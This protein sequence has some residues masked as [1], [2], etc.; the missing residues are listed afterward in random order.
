MTEA[1][2]S[3]LSFSMYWMSLFFCGSDTF[4]FAGVIL[5]FSASGSEEISQP[6]NLFNK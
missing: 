1:N 3:K 2:M 5:G 6:I 4:L